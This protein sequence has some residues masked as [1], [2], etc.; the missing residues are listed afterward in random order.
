MKQS[1][2]YAFL[3]GAVAGGII[4]LLFAPD[5]GSETRRKISSKVKET[6]N[7]TKEQIE[8]L[9]S[10]LRGRAADG[11]SELEGDIVELEEQ[12]EDIEEKIRGKK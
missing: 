1:N 5:K 2:F 12:L 3:A 11:I 8:H 6:G 7:M 4:A 9:L 10:Y